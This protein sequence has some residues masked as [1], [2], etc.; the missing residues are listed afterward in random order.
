MLSEQLGNGEF[1]GK[2]FQICSRDNPKILD[3]LYT[4]KVYFKNIELQKKDESKENLFM[5]LVN[6]LKLY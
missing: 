1:V 4:N 3:N 5:L 2:T 6:K